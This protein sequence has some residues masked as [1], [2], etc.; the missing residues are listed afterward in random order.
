MLENGQ[1][2]RNRELREHVAGIDGKIAL[3]IVC[4]NSMN[5]YVCTRKLLQAHI[6]IYNDRR[7]YVGDELPTNTDG[8]EI[9]D[10]TGQYLVPGYSEPHAHPFYLYNPVDLAY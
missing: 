3:S 10:F 4:T 7:I 5:L 9:I 1:F 6:W 8:T 2:W